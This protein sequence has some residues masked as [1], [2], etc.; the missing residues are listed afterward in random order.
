MKLKE[1]NDNQLFLKVNCC[2]NSFQ[3]M[4]ISTFIKG[5]E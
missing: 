5:K 4:F 1:Q 3:N 2:M